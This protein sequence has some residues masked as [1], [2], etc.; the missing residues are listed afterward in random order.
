MTRVLRWFLRKVVAPFHVYSVACMHRSGFIWS[1]IYT[2]AERLTL[3]E[4][5]DRARNTRPHSW[6]DNFHGPFKP[7]DV[8]GTAVT[9]DVIYLGGK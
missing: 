2:E 1:F 4:L 8:V 6:D 7:D 3:D 5:T 9:H